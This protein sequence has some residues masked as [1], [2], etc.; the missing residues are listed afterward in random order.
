MQWTGKES[1]VGRVQEA[2]KNSKTYSSSRKNSRAGPKVEE[3]ANLGG[4]V[5]GRK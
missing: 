1:G 2:L 4:R 5:K 3:Q